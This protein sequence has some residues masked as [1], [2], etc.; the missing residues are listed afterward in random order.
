MWIISKASCF[1]L[2]IISFSVMTITRSWL[3]I[4]PDIFLCILY[5]SP[6]LFH[7]LCANLVPDPAM[8][9]FRRCVWKKFTGKS[10]DLLTNCLSVSLT[11]TIACIIPTRGSRTGHLE[12]NP[13]AWEP[14]LHVLHSSEGCVSSGSSL[15]ESYKTLQGSQVLSSSPSL[16]TW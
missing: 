1:S 2:F 7:F 10:L 9:S 8:K 14:L 6:F 4:L 5:E 12:P 16:T 11:P 15:I 13:L 3:Y